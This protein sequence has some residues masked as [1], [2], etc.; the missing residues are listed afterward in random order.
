MTVRGCR[1][2]DASRIGE[3]YNHFVRN[4][5]VTFEEAPVSEDEILERIRKVTTRLPWLV[6]EEHGSVV[7][8]AYAAAWHTRSAY[9]Y[10]VESTIYLAPDA[11]G[12]GFGT[13]LYAELLEELKGRSIRCVIGGIALPNPASVALHEKLGFSKVGHLTDVGRKFD[14]WI[15]VG[16]WQLLL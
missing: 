11:C 13:R 2:S 14:R 4:T 5:I 8:Y 10:S 9:R 15:D 12:R 1:E 6:W 16:Y 3:I 7:G